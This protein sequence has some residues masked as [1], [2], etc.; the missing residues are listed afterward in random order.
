MG[1]SIGPTPPAQEMS[2]TEVSYRLSCEC[3]GVTPRPPLTELWD[4]D[5]VR[6]QV[7]A[8][9]TGLGRRPILLGPEVGYRPLKTRALG[10]PPCAPSP[11]RS[12]TMPHPGRIVRG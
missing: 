6:R 7:E 11:V 2:F 3:W 5:R 10:H 4:L 1:L 9:F 12:V 8:A